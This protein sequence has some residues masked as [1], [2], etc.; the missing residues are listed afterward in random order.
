MVIAVVDPGV[1]SDR[2]AVT[3]CA[4]D[5]WFVGP[6]NGLLS[7][8]AARAHSRRCFRIVDG[9]A[10]S[11]SF[12]GRDLFAPVAATLATAPDACVRLEPVAKLDV[13]LDPGDLAQVIYVDHY[14]NAMTGLCADALPA[15]AH[16]MLGAREIP[17]SRVFSDVPEGAL[18]CYANSIGL[19]EIAANRA[20][21]AG[22]CDI[23][24]GDSVRVVVPP[25][26]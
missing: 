16:L 8:V 25:G 14:G 26:S 19:L 24:V 23:S 12:H 22:L 1:G 9:A 2:H 6:D 13:S 11:A 17:R 21:A 20:S 18:F 7:I 3:V 4:D 5:R 15:H 10:A